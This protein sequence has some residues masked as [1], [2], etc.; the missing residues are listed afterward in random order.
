MNK[1]KK[2]K[3]NFGNSI[4]YEGAQIDKDVKIGP[5]SIIYPNT[6]IASGV[7]IASACI[8]GKPPAIGGN[9]MPLINSKDLTIIK[10]NVY[11]GDQSIVYSGVLIGENAYLADRSFLREG[12]IIEND[13]VIGTGVVVSFGSIVGPYTKIMTGSNIGGNAKIGTKCFIGVHVCSINDNTPLTWKPREQQISADI[14]DGVFIG[15]NST[16]LP[17]I[18]ISDNITVGAGSV[19]TKNLDCESSLYMGVPAKFI[20]K[21]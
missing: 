5:F 3:H 19:I 15:S 2:K 4:I 21:K 8:I 17:S 7:T 10:N 11:I 20:R 6:I 1:L 12:V 13:V 16:I 9:Q 18:K 14:G